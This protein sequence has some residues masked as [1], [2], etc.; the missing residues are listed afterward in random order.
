MIFSDIVEYYNELNTVINELDI[1]YNDALAIKSA[2]NEILKETIKS[3]YIVNNSSY[4]SD[5]RNITTKHI[6]IVKESMLKQNLLKLGKLIRTIEH[7][8]TDNMIF[9]ISSN[10][11]GSLEYYAENIHNFN[12]SSSNDFT[13]NFINLLLSVNT[14]VTQIN[15]IKGLIIELNRFEFILM[16]APENITEDNIFSIRLYNENLSVKDINLLMKSISNIYERSCTLFNI[17]IN[18]YPL[19]PIKI[20]SGSL[21]EK[22]FGHEKILRFMGDLFNR[23]INYIYRN[24]TNEGRLSTV[25]TK[26]DTLKEEIKL[27][28][29]CEEHGIDTSTAKEILHDNLNVLCNDILKVTTSSTKISVNGQT[30]D[31][32]KSID[33]KMLENIPKNITATTEHDRINNNSDI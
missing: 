15:L 8:N 20:E 17:S 13:N 25:G 27:I 19:E 7:Q 5:I 26:I 24:F 32:A 28:D 23:T 33:A 16:N 9:T 10:L 30:Y 1:F 3:A 18:D 31:L 11:I 21:L 2:S 12:N 4:Y 29:L 14:F 6:K 22:V